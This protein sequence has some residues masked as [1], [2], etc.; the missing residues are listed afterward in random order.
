MPHRF[1]TIRKGCSFSLHGLAI[2]NCSIFIVPLLCIEGGESFEL[3]CNIAFQFLT[4]P[5]SSSSSEKE[6]DVVK[7]CTLKEVCAKK[8][9]KNG[10]LASNREFLN[11][12][13]LNI[14]ML[15]Y[16]A[17][18]KVLQIFVHI[19]KLKVGKSA[20]LKTFKNVRWTLLSS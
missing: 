17:F 12:N 1:F 6:Q 5:S 18:I 10:N 15:Y 13:E 16:F 2:T 3:A 14:L 20:T 9:E 11:K 8:L 4:A 19:V 7:A